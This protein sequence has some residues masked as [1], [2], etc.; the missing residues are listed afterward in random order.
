[1]SMSWTRRPS[2]RN[3][4]SLPSL[5]TK[6]IATRTITSLS[7]IGWTTR[8]N[9]KMKPSQRESYWTSR[10]TT[11][12]LM[13]SLKRMSWTTRKRSYCRSLNSKTRS[14]NRMR[15]LKT[16]YLNK[17]LKKTT[18]RTRTRSCLNCRTMRMK[19]T[20][21]SYYWTRMTKNS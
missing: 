14:L 17:S 8:M 21:N 18:K 15:S 12:S 4:K 3:S 1:M 10:T 7:W 20:K 11:G 16:N 5:R 9:T 19:T 2:H 6:L 13:K